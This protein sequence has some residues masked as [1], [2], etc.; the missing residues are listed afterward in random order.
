MKARYLRRVAY[1]LLALVLAAGLLWLALPRLLGFAAGRWLRVPGLE[2]LALDLDTVGPRRLHARNVRGVYRTPSGDRLVFALQGV[3]MDY[4][5]AQR[6]IGQL[7]IDQGHLE[8]TPNPEPADSTGTGWPELAWPALPLKQVQVADLQVTVHLSGQDPLQARGRLDVQQDGETLRAAF[9]T[10][11]EHMRLSA[12]PG[13]TVDIQAEWQHQDG[14][15]A[16][17][18]LRLGRHPA[19]QPAWLEARAPLPLFEKLAATLGLPRPPGSLTGDVA[20][21][22]EATLSNNST[23]VQAATAKATLSKAQWQMN[24]HPQEA[25]A[26]TLDG[27]LSG[28]WTEEATRITLLPGLHWQARSDLH[29]LSGQGRIDAPTTVDIDAHGIRSANDLAF[30]LQSPQWGQWSGVLR[31]PQLHSDTGPAD[32]K[33]AN[34][35]LHFKGQMKQWRQAGLQARDLRTTGDATMHWSRTNGLRVTTTLQ[36]TT[37][38]LSSSGRSPVSLVR[39]AWTVTAQAQARA[40][41]D[42][43]QNLVLQGQAKSEALNIRSGAAQTISTGPLR[44]TLLPSYPARMQGELLLATPTIRYDK[45]PAS[46]LQAR[47]RLNKS[48]LRAEGGLRLQESNEPVRFSASHSLERACGQA[49]L[50]TTQQSLAAW[51]QQ[52]EPHWPVLQPLSVQQGAADA[53]MTL[54]WCL[55]PHMKINAKGSLAAP[56]VGF[57]WEKARIKDANIQLT[58]DSLQPLQGR[59]QFAT[60]QGHLANGSP[61]TD[62]H[63]DLALKHNMFSVHTAKVQV[64]GGQVAADASNMPW[65]PSPQKN[66]PLHVKGVD[67]SQLLALFDID[68]LNASGQLAGV[69]P[70]GW[71]DGAIEIRDGHLG[72]TNGGIIRYTPKQPT[73]NNPGLQALRNF[74]YRQLDADISYNSEGNYRALIT[75]EGHN[76]DF[77]NGYPVRMRLNIGGS[78]PG[79]FRA[80]LFSGDFSRH[81]V[82]QLQSGKLQ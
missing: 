11:A 8:L 45:W 74:H 41:A 77:Y 38:R 62:L 21:Q 31:Q 22:A 58:L 50:A 40:G 72:S 14:Q 57:G 78:L 53:G 24:G 68:G 6:Q 67:L 44:L 12:T 18:R 76:P 17:A 73:H 37:G 3:H 9:H 20:L 23:R 15:N 13:A 80:A 26:L 10:P 43:W 46:D 82:Q 1:T 61:L 49:N 36:A 52:L 64:L 65:P 60:P 55:Q 70:L 51:A 4:A 56:K 32:W 28:H 27:S 59:L 19:Q 35:Q 79:A 47:L 71:R 2:T 63:L 42:L 75:L 7:N 81:I 30:A 16:T 66:L 54:N 29:Q 48:L 34:A 33:A 69:L 39:S 25:T 5:L